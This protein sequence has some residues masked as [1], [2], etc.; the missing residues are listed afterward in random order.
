MAN[1]IPYILV[2]ALSCIATFHYCESKHQDF[3]QKLNA[4]TQKAKENQALRE[5]E[6]N[7]VISDL[8]EES[9]GR[10][11]E[12]ER[13]SSERAVLIKRLRD[14]GSTSSGRTGTENKSSGSDTETTTGTELS[15]EATE[16]LLRLT[17]DA[18]LLREQLSLCQNWAK[19][20]TR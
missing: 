2:V 14:P 5:Q 16:F 10:Q 3:I 17:R 19:S 20:L 13:L 18:D 11:M 6:L 7:S 1:L 15:R 4:T 8:L 9:H 12:I